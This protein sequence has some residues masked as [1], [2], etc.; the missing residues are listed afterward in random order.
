M[1]QLLKYIALYCVV[2]GGLFIIWAILFSVLGWFKG[3]Q[4]KWKNTI[5]FTSF[6]SFPLFVFLVLSAFHVY[7]PQLF[8][9]HVPPSSES[10][11]TEVEAVDKTGKQL[12][13]A[14]DDPESLTLQQL[15]N[16]VDK[17]KEYAAQA[18]ELNRIQE[19][20]IVT[21]RETVEQETAKAKEAQDIA[22]K[23]KSITAEQLDAV[24]FIITKDAN[25]QARQ[26]FINGVITSFP[27]GVLT[28][29]IGA[30]LWD[31][32]RPKRRAALS[33]VERTIEDTL[34]AAGHVI[35]KGT[36]Q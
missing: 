35:H 8:F 24:K 29:I 11:R 21:L 9:K 16:L 19:T 7:P 36:T 30:A 6:L 5:V 23:V 25:E 31:R 28:S 33:T 22:E 32:F 3:T 15:R 14:F 12:I 4:S 27:L 1:I 18:G 17:V 34:S 13:A 26:S 2:S 10:L 20:Q